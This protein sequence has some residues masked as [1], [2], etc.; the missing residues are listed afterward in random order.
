MASHLVRPRLGAEDAV[1]QR[2][3][4][5]VEALALHLVD[6]R[7]HVGRGHH[8]DVRAEVADEIGGRR[9]RTVSL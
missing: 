7:K 4:G 1:A 2:A 9:D 8:D 6:D 5:R 3:G